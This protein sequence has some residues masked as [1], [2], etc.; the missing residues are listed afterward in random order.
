MDEGLLNLQPLSYWKS[1]KEDGTK[2]SSLRVNNSYIF[3]RKQILLYT[4]RVNITCKL[5]YSNMHALSY[6]IQLYHTILI[7]CFLINFSAGSNA[8]TYVETMAFLLECTIK[9]APEEGYTYFHD[10]ELKIITFLKL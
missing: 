4:L 7:F 8:R 9:G 6:S 2:Y 3:R 1:F 10:C 5:S